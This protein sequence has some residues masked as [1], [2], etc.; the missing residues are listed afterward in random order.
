MEAATTALRECVTKPADPAAMWAAI[1]ALSAELEKAGHEKPKRPRGRPRT[2]DE[3]DDQLIEHWPMGTHPPLPNFASPGTE[4]HRQYQS[5]L[6]SFEA[7][8]RANEEG[9]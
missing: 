3:D 6:D 9:T 4:A 2:N 7:Y 8:R 1:E 5:L